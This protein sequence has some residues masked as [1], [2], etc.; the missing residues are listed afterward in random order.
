MS[1]LYIK[2]VANV[3]IDLAIKDRVTIIGGDSGTGRTYLTSII[4]AAIKNRG[5][6]LE[7]NVDVARFVVI[8]DE[9]NIE[10][11]NAIK[12]K[13]IVFIDRYDGYSE[14]NKRRIWQKM[15]NVSA[16]WIIMSRYPD[17]PQY[18]VNGG[19]RCEELKYVK[20]QSEIT[21]CFK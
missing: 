20:N 11:V 14:E 1:N 2:S 15:K 19:A 6:T 16:A 3:V 4:K 9:L 13:S 12:E 5:F 18:A 17:I 7:S 21:F 10:N 8:E